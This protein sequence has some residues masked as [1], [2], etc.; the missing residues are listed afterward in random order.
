[1]KIEARK[2]R[3]GG[4]LIQRVLFVGSTQWQGT[5]GDG[6]RWLPATGLRNKCYS[7]VG[8]VS[9]ACKGLSINI[10]TNTNIHQ[11]CILHQAK[12]FIVRDSRPQVDVVVH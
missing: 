5:D 8:T 10:N 6:C 4:E 7:T 12:A 2:R 1:M 9:D 11:E 3:Q